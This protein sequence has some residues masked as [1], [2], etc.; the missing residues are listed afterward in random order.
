MSSDAKMGLGIVGALAVCCGGPLILSALASGAVLGALGALWD[1]GRL[2]LLAG[3]A[4]L[5]VAAVWLLARRLA[6][7][8]HPAV[9]CC[10]VPMS[11]PGVG[12]GDTAPVHATSVDNTTAAVAS[13]DRTTAD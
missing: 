7:P 2:V 12:H 9:D 4:V 13:R 1:G 3:G 5:I 6:S 11:S 8:A 10:A